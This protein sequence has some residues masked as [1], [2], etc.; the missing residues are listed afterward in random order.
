MYK[1]FKELDNK[2]SYD[3]WLATGAMGEE[4]PHKFYN[5]SYP[6]DF[7]TKYNTI[8][9]LIGN[10]VDLIIAINP[11]FI[12]D[13]EYDEMSDWIDLGSFF[14]S[15]EEDIYNFQKYKQKTLLQAN[16]LE[17]ML[18]NCK[19]YCDILSVIYPTFKEK[20][21]NAK[22]VFSSALK[23]LHKVKYMKMP[24]IKNGWKYTF[25]D[26]W[27]IT[28]NNYLYNT[29]TGHQEGNLIY[30]FSRVRSILRRN[31]KIEKISFYEEIKETLERGYITRGQFANYTNLIAKVPTILTPEVMYDIERFKEICKLDLP[32]EKL[33]DI[34][35]Y[36]HTER[37]YQIRLVNVIVGFLAAQD[38]FY[39]AFCRLNDSRN[40]KVIIE[41]LSALKLDDVFVKF[42]GFHKISSVEEK[43]ITTSSI[44]VVD[45]FKEYLNRGW[46]IDIIP[47]LVY[48]KYLDTLTEMDF[49]GALVDKYIS[50]ELSSY[51]G[52]GRIRIKYKDH[53]ESN[54]R[55]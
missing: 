51:K 38:S 28:P 27:Y 53:I 18:W 54:K 23:D 4:I 36:P 3:V 34:K 49:E 31:E 11:S 48:D 2:K 19:R 17:D 12:N 39:K 7:F 55:N 10:I 1:Y 14:E 8:F 13:I 26:A 25:P 50:K 6:T 9:E 32:L 43:T 30:P 5:Y 41:Q 37:S 33:L 15:Q 44:D 22:N 40:K 52:K 24:E 46:N 16:E 47:G 45:K 21:N 42:I 35:N 20:L 29:G